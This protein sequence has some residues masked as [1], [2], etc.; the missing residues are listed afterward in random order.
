MYEIP[1][2]KG[3]TECLVSEEVIDKNEKPVLIYEKQSA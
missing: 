1:S 3:I 2:E